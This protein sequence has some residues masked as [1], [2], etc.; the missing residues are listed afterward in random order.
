V[1]ILPRYTTEIPHHRTAGQARTGSKRKNRGNGRSSPPNSSND[2]CSWSRP[3]NDDKRNRHTRHTGRTPF[4]MPILSCCC[5]QALEKP[6]KLETYDGTTNPDEHIDTVL[7]YH[8][9]RGSVKC[10]L[11]VL[12]LTRA[13]MIWFK[14][15][16]SGLMERT[17]NGLLLPLHSK[18]TTTKNNGI[19]QQHSPR[20]RGIP[21]RLY[22]TLYT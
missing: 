4:T 17:T 11:F 2:G 22:R 20:E 19:S 1:K 13:N 3:T 21:L 16:F 10:K 12:T 6:P 18:E 9:A 5:S 14:G 15:W 8:Q 7:D